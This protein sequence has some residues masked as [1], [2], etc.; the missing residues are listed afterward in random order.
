MVNANS[1][2]VVSDVDV[3]M[4]TVSGLAVLVTPPSV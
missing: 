4:L 1:V 3:T 2:F